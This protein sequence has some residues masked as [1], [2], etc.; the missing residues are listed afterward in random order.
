MLGPDPFPSP[1]GLAELDAAT[2]GDLVVGA[3]DDFLAVADTADLSRPSRLSGWTGREACIHLGSWDDHPVL[4]GILDAAQSGGGAAPDNVDTDNA[5]L[6][7]AHQDASADDVLAALRRS[8]DV[9]EQW[10]DSA[11]P[12]ALGTARVR[13]TVGEL[14]LLSLLHAGCYELAVHALDLA[15]CGAAAPSEFLLDRGL[16]SLLDVTGALAARTDIDI[17]VTAQTPTG[18]WSFTSTAQGWTTQKVATGTFEGAGVRGSA[19]DL[20]D[21]S[22]GRTSIPTLLVTRRITVQQLTSFMR[23]APLLDD[24]PGLPGGAALKTGVSGLGA[25]TGGVSR[26]LGRLRR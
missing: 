19:A 5:R 2:V 24:V 7:A 23:L 13:S 17:T 21:V 4:V 15:P 16:A 9:L 10:F 26:M 3:W 22:A 18:G 25:V 20:L 8:R 6:V 12:A 14:P 11:E 1:C